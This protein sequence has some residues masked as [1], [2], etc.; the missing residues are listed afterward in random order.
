MSII[1]GNPIIEI[2]EYNQS[3]YNVEVGWYFYDEYWTDLIG[4]FP[5]ESICDIELSLYCEE[6]AKKD[7]L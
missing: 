4:P 2:T 7:Y 3:L 1:D 6:V 5:N